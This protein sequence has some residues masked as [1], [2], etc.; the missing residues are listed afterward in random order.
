MYNRYKPRPPPTTP[1]PIPL[2]TV[3]DIRKT[4]EAKAKANH[5]IYKE[6][7]QMCYKQIQTKSTLSKNSVFFIMPPIVVGKP[8]YNMEHAGNYIMAKLEKGGFKV[9]RQSNVCLFIQW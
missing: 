2:L 7:L 6:I 9:S 5:E 4:R 8:T 3:K 1:P